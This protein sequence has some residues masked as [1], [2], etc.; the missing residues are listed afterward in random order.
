MA[1][2]WTRGEGDSK[3]SFNSLRR[4]A[5]L[6][7]SAGLVA[8]GL[9]VLAV[10][11]VASSSRSEQQAAGGLAVAPDATG[12][13]QPLANAESAAAAPDTFLAVSWI[14]SDSSGT[15]EVRVLS[16]GG[17]ELGRVAT[18]S[19]PMASLR[20]SR[21][22][23]LVSDAPLTP[24]G[25]ARRTRL[26]VLDLDNALAL[27]REIDLPDRVMYT[28]F[29][30]R[31]RLSAEETQLFYE[32][33]RPQTHE[34]AIGTLNLDS[35]S[36]VPSFAILPAGCDFAPIDVSR[37]GLYAACRNGAI[38]RLSA[39]TATV[40]GRVPNAFADQRTGVAAEIEAVFARD[41]G[42]VIAVRTNGEI[43]EVTAGGS[44][45]SLGRAIPDGFRVQY[46]GLEGRVE[47]SVAIPYRRLG[48]QKAAGVVLLDVRTGGT[49]PVTNGEGSTF[50]Q[51][52]A[53][54]T[55]LQKETSIELVSDGGQV[56]VLPLPQDNAV[57][58]AIT[59]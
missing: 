9:G 13:T 6:L 30:Q 18:A 45:R 37:A 48:E 31:M 29:A 25:T 3:P 44:T 23:L 39:G 38:V 21:R 10:W 12:L 42:T 2:N 16:A 27:K 4:R 36:S 52:T 55:L 50:I 56:T 14:R 46:V 43:V 33:Y 59:R 22:E 51:R 49:R 20:S 28:I 5:V 8:A 11:Q 35:G 32:V 34:W 7:L 47:Q 54:G 24:D 41:D 58:W 53:A 26:R 15:H 40:M 1:L 57:E 19:Y 17:Q